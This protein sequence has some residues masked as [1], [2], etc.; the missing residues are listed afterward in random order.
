MTVWTPK[1]VFNILK[2]IWEAL[3]LEKKELKAIYGALEAQCKLLQRNQLSKE[4][5]LWDHWRGWRCAALHGKAWPG[6][7]D[8]AK[9]WRTM[10]ATAGWQQQRGPWVPAQTLQAPAAW[11]LYIVSA[12]LPTSSGI[13]KLT[14]AFCMS[15]RKG[16]FTSWL[17]ENAFTW[18]IPHHVFPCGFY[19]ACGRAVAPEQGVSA[20]LWLRGCEV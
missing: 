18:H 1:L 17:L 13:G 6:G 8:G 3:Q 12:G 2:T 14:W 16:L 10:A 9:P 7:V 11:L 19:P 4:M 20:D 5:Y 15:E